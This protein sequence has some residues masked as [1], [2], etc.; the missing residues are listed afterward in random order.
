M[1]TYA[2]RGLFRDVTDVFAWGI[3]KIYDLVLYLFDLAV[4]IFTY[5]WEKYLEL[6]FFE[7]FVAL[8]TFPA[9]FAVVLPMADFYIFEANFNINNPLAVYMIGIVAVMIASLYY[10]HR[11]R[12]FVRIGINAYFLFWVIYLP[13]AHELTKAE[14]H[15]ILFGYWMNIVVPV[16]YIVISLISFIHNRE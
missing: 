12:I 11:F 8:T 13:L 4:R 2:L 9:F 3:S 14:P 10:P 15:R 6:D 16:A 1:N 5:I 7:K